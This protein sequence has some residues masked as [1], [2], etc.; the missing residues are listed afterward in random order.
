MLDVVARESHQPVRVFNLLVEGAHNFYA[1][2]A[3]ALPFVLT[4]NNDRICPPVGRAGVE[5]AER[6]VTGYHGTD[7][8]TIISI[9]ESGVMRPH[10]E[11]VQL[12]GTSYQAAFAHGGDIGRRATFSL[13]I[14]VGV[15][16]ASRVSRSSTPGVPD[17][18]T[19]RGSADLPVHAKRLFV[20]RPDGDGG[21]ITEA[22]E[23]QEAILS[24]LRGQ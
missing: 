1:A 21:F 11:A 22:I 19:I 16:S 9:I 7:G 6:R 4:H 20:R 2:S 13:E 14:E 10:R 3:K 24:Y 8:D 12:S 5:A 23:G 18:L 17:T 15:S